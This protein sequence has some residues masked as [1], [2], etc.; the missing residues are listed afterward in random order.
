MSER[1][2]A[3]LFVFLFVPLWPL[4]LAMLLCDAVRGIGNGFRKLYRRLTQPRNTAE[5]L[6]E[7]DK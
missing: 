7:G 5:Q 2:K 3:Y 6:K 1:E 4:G